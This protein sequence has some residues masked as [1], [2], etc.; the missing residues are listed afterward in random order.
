MN[1]NIISEII[2][3]RRRF[4]KLIEEYFQRV[5]RLFVQIKLKELRLV[6]ANIVLNS[7]VRDN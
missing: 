6:V 7:I 2:S 3:I 1:S 4:K 5:E